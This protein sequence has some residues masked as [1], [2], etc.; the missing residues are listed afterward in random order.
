MLKNSS[1][2]YYD[3]QCKLLRSSLM[4]KCN[5]IHSSVLSKGS[6]AGPLY[7]VISNKSSPF[8][9]CSFTNSG[10]LSAQIQAETIVI[11]QNWQIRASSVESNLWPLCAYGAA[12]IAKI[13]PH[14]S[15]DFANSSIVAYFDLWVKIYQ[16]SPVTFKSYGNSNMST[17]LKGLPLF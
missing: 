2:F 8:W 11:S 10:Y 5:N 4:P 7:T 3:V 6:T 12:T 9:Y 15:L 1:S 17:S 16:Y 13:A 14:T